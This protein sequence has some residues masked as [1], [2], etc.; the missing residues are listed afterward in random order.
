[1]RF[2]CGCKHVAC[3]LALLAGLSAL[4]LDAHALQLVE[5]ADGQTVT[6]K[7]SSR[8]LTRLAMADGGHIARVW[9]LEDHMQVQ[10][11]R[12]GGQVFLRPVPGASH[13]AF[14]FFVRD[15]RGATYTVLAVPVDMPSDTV[16]LRAKA[17]L[18]ETA[19]HTSTRALAYIT[20][21][22]SLIRAMARGGVPDGYVPT[23]LDTP[24]P[25]WAKTRLVL[26]ARFSGALTGEVY[27]LTN[28]S[29]KPMRLDERELGDLVDDV[30]AVAIADPVL[31]PSATT[32]VYLVR[33]PQ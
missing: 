33:R 6:V 29:K 21:I 9:G 2:K 20:G 26:V 15:D 31:A 10:P 32:R 25:L 3:R 11:D 7:V 24:V 5:V 17:Q 23:A 19:A 8:D 27:R 30:E 12:Q 1:M 28:L 22:K 18:A 14:S 13:Q 16:L 4:S